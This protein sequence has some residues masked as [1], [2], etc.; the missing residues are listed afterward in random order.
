MFLISQFAIIFHPEDEYI[1]AGNCSAVL[2]ESI[3]PYYTHYSPY[4]SRN[5]NLISFNFYV[6]LND[7]FHSRVFYLSTL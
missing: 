7:R 6:I 4:Y 5:F 1:S 3:S 2:F